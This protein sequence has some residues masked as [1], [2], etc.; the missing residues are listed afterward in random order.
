MAQPIGINFIPSD[1]QAMNGPKQ[2]NLEGDLGQAF[3]ILSLQLPRRPQIGGIAPQALLQSPGGSNPLAAVFEALLRGM[4]PPAGSGA[5]G[6]APTPTPG[7]IPPPRIIP[8]DQGDR[9]PAPPPPN[10][11]YR[12]GPSPT[13]PTAPTVPGRTPGTVFPRRSY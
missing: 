13:T 1:E 2:G 9:F 7:A 8:G 12:P 10:E 5:P 3:K 4:R 11:P 6:G